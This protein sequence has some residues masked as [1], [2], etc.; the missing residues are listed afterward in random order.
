MNNPRLLS[1]REVAERLNLSEGSVYA[2]INGHK[3]AHLRIGR[4]TIR[5]NERDLDDYIES[6]RIEKCE[7]TTKPLRQKLKHLHLN[8]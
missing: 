6:C 8:R 4:R 5:V 7:E 3:L 1:V 2:L